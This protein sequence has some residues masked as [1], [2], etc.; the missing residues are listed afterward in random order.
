MSC[1]QA[2]EQLLEIIENKRDE[3]QEEIGT[4]KANSK[5]ISLKFIAFLFYLVAISE[6]TICVGLGRVGCADQKIVAAKLK[7]FTSIDI[8]EPLHSF[9]ITG[10]MH[11]M[12]QEMLKM[13]TLDPSILQ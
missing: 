12:E 4:D 13:F 10:N 6:D 3:G 5:L 8:G 1:S 7:D 11:L 9:V 2:A